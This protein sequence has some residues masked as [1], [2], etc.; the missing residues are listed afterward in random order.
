MNTFH[1]YIDA[2]LPNAPKKDF[3]A[4]ISL[5]VF[6]GIL[7]GSVSAFDGV[8][9]SAYN[10]QSNAAGLNSGAIVQSS[11]QVIKPTAT[12]ACYTLPPCAT[13][14]GIKCL[15]VIPAG[16]SLCKPA[17]TPSVTAIPTP[18]KPITAT[19]V[20]VPP[21]TAGH[22]CPQYRIACPTESVPVTITATG[23]VTTSPSEIITP[24]A[25]LI[26][27]VSPTIRTS[28]TPTIVT[29]TPTCVSVPPCVAGHE[30]PQYVKVCPPVVTVKVTETTVPSLPIGTTVANNRVIIPT[31]TGTEK[32][33]TNVFAS[34]WQ[35]IS[36]FFHF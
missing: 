17:I 21:C 18:T 35:A 36:N 30:C 15:I 32:P 12:P 19:C 14:S 26:P 10:T 4:I 22:E 2:L 33:A 29:V 34:M 13:A 9:P 27:S 23:T 3:F 11:V 25:T 8:S 5:I 24:V 20:S 1:T 28:V 16:M 6:G 31:I 7:L